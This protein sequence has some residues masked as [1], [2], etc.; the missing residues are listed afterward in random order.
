MILR[1]TFDSVKNNKPVYFNCAAG[2]DRTGTVA[3]VLEAILGMDQSD[4]DKEYEL[5]SFYSGTLSDATARRRDEN[6]WKDLIAGIC[7]KAPS[8]SENKIRDGAVRFALDLGFTI[9]EINDFRSA[10]INGM[11]EPLTVK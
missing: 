11:P 9:D 8:G 10:V 6:E 7:A 5:T 1:A 4:I 3:C 2:A